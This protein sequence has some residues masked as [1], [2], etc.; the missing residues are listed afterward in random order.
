MSFLEG[1]TQFFF[2]ILSAMM[3]KDKLL[4]PDT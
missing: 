4:D 2:I 1:V 3:M